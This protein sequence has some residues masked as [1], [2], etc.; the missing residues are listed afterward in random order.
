MFTAKDYRILSNMVFK[1]DYPG[2]KPGVVES[3]DGDGKLDDQKK[4]AHVAF[5]YIKG[6]YGPLTM[7]LER[8]HEKALDTA[9]EMGIPKAYWPAI[10]YSVI[11]VLEYPP[12][13]V[14]HPHK[15]FD[16]FT[17]NLYRN[18]PGLV[19]PQIPIHYGE[20]LEMIN[21][22]FPATEH[23][24]E[25]SGMT[26]YSMVYFAIPDHNQVLPNGQTVGAWLEERL[27]RSRY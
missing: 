2:Y 5:K 1:D 18:L 16:L 6:N 21:P 8:V 4:Y 19:E 13:A 10:E 11:R 12:G 25:A 24:V 14:S 23:H 3:P 22:N 15:D 26:Q 17:I 7:Y 27:K 20:M 9:M